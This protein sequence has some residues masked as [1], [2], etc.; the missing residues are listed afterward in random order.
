MGSEPTEYLLVFR[1]TTPERYEAMTR[2]ERQ[3]ALER[4][5][6]WCDEIAAQG[7][8]KHGNTLAPMARVVAAPGRTR[9]VDGPFTET[10]ELIAGYLLLA[11]SSLDEATSIAERCPSLPYGMV[12]E[13]RPVS[14]TCHLARSLGWETMRG[15]VA[16]P[17]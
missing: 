9:V 8:L 15:P 1:E 13:V 16:Q 10:K 11:A 12:I 2:D 6:A 5:N 4:W 3:R 17:A 14:P 7:K